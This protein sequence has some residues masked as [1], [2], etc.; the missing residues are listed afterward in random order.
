M[1]QVWWVQ[2]DIGI[3]YGSGMVTGA[4]LIDYISGYYVQNGAKLNAAKIP[5]VFSLLCEYLQQT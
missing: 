4:T 5:V 1:G 3:V 2:G